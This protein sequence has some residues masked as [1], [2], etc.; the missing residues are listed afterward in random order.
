MVHIGLI[1]FVQGYCK[2][3][4]ICRR[5]SLKVYYNIALYTKYENENKSKELNSDAQKYV[6]YF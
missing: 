2:Q 6:S 3:F 1:V 4:G 5:N